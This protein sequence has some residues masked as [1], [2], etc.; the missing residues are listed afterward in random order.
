MIALLKPQSERVHSSTQENLALVFWLAQWYDSN[1]SKN[2]DRCQGIL[3]R[4]PNT[5]TKGNFAPYK[6]NRSLPLL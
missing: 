1:S 3:M 5:R 4:Q 2:S 6:P